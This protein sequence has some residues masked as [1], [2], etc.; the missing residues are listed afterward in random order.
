[1]PRSST[2]IIRQAGAW[3]I[4]WIEGAPGANC[5]ER[6]REALPETLEDLELDLQERNGEALPEA[7]EVTLHE[8]S[9]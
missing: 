5:Q 6:T 4:G 7:L 3:W 9:S 8:R 2:A 1:M